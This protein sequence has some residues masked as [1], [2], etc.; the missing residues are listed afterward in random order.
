[1]SRPIGSKNVNWDKEILY[2]LYYRQGL[3]SNEVGIKLGATGSAVRQAMVKLGMKLRTLSEA[4]SGEKHYAWKGGKNKTSTGYIEIYKPE[5]HRA[6]VRGYVK[7]HILVWEESNRRKLRSDE[8]IHHLNGIKT[9]NRPENLL[10]LRNEEHRCWIP[11]LQ[12]HIRYLESELKRCS[13]GV[14]EF[15]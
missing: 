6:G 14:L 1:M 4:T 3:N 15:P 13:Q 8:V 12:K 11:A 9:D 10:A 7:E 2:D 5:H